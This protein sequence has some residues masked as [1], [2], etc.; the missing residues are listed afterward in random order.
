M[1]HAV[2][3]LERWNHPDRGIWE[4]RGEPRHFTSSKLMCWV[5]G[6]RGARLARMRGEATAR[7]GGAAA[8]IHADICENAQDER[9]VFSQPYDTDELDASLLLIPMM[10]FLP[11]RP[12]SPPHGPCDHRR[13][14]RGGLVRRYRPRDRRRPRRAGGNV[15]GLLVLAGLGARRD[16]RAPPRRDLCEKVLS[17]ASPLLLYGEEL[18]P[19]SGRHLGNFPQALTHLSLINAVLHVIN[20]EQDAHRR[21]MGREVPEGEA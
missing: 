7:T 3:A 15:H 21:A 1:A 16:R 18:D 13:A 14:D 5:A 10:G 6:D 2:D 12:P 8:E 11:L 19:R 4:V 20:D 9:G 17:Y